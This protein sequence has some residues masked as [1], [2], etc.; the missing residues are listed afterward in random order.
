MHVA[1]I[2]LRYFREDATI[3]ERWIGEELLGKSAEEEVPDAMVEDVAGARVIEFG[4]TYDSRRVA[5]FH[6]HCS[7]R[8]LRYELW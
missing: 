1:E 5:K 4:G 3:R 7:S 2:Y 6:R 8:G